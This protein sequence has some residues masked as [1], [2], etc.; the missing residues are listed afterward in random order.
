MIENS[1]SR[2]KVTRKPFRLRNT[3]AQFIRK[4][5][6]LP[7]Y[8]T[9]I[10][11]ITIPE[12]EDDR[13]TD[14]SYRTIV[15]EFDKKKMNEDLTALESNVRLKMHHHSITKNLEV[16]ET[17]PYKEK[18]D[19]DEHIEVEI[20]NIASR[21][22]KVQ[23]N[24]DKLFIYV[25]RDCNQINKHGFYMLKKRYKSW[26]N[27]F[28]LHFHTG[29]SITRQ[30]TSKNGSMALHLFSL[31]AKLQRILLSAEIISHDRS[32]SSLQDSIWF[33]HLYNIKSDYKKM[34]TKIFNSPTCL[35]LPGSSTGL[36]FSI[37]DLIHLPKSLHLHET[38]PIGEL[39][40]SELIKNILHLLQTP[41]IGFFLMTD[42]HKRTHILYYVNLLMLRLGD[43]V[44]RKFFTNEY[45]D[46]EKYYMIDTASGL[47]CANSRLFNVAFY[48]WTYMSLAYMFRFKSKECGSFR[49]FHALPRTVRLKWNVMKNIRSG[50]KFCKNI[51]MNNIC[52]RKET[53]YLFFDRFEDSMISILAIPGIVHYEQSCTEKKMGPWI[54]YSIGK[55][56]R[57]ELLE[58]YQPEVYTFISKYMLYFSKTILNQTDM[59]IPFM[60]YVDRYIK[61]IYYKNSFF[62]ET[63]LGVNDDESEVMFTPEQKKSLKTNKMFQMQ[64]MY[65]PHMIQNVLCLE[66]MSFWFLE[67]T[68][69]YDFI[70]TYVVFYHQIYMHSI[71]TLKTRINNK[72]KKYPLIVQTNPSRFDVVFEEKTYYCNYDIRNAIVLWF[73]IIT[74]R[75]RGVLCYE[76]DTFYIGDS[77]PKEFLFQDEGEED[78]GEDD[79]DL[80][81]E[82]VSSFYFMAPIISM[83]ETQV[84]KFNP[85]NVGGTDYTAMK[86]QPNGVDISRNKVII[87]KGDKE[88]DHECLESVLATDK[89]ER[90]ME[91]MNEIDRYGRRNS[92]IIENPWDSSKKY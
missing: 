46:V 35:P 24:I 50:Y 60:R 17:R 47:F 90:K 16:C 44:T 34:Y 77:I 40:L 55:E 22:P 10:Q 13:L 23:Y 7:W 8:I 73:T 38:I 5:R 42:I 36:G 62:E 58:K 68:S 15:K 18:H 59:K 30:K 63:F 33:R 49:D 56:T 81:D 32:V 27:F 78:E 3:E 39:T 28:L 1:F 69:K 51:L 85:I 53:M 41:M 88:Y 11:K 9:I 20:V 65:I 76:F 54:R 72:S 2:N 4:R 25:C 87:E 31:I 80:I 29:I 75:I 43:F 19:F 70:E 6:N 48:L 71:D 21:I 82:S 57:M 64:Y 91:R 86:F 83:P 74:S 92:K 61:G 84:H 26:T 12:I 79:R 89:Y 37:V 45:L 67:L 14:I 66:A 52:K